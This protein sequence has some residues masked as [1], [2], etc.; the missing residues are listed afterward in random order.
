MDIEFSSKAIDLNAFE[1]P[2]FR[3][4]AKHAKLIWALDERG[5]QLFMGRKYLMELADG[6]HGNEGAPI[7]FFE[8]DHLNDI[9]DITID[10]FGDASLAFVFNVDWNTNAPE[11][12][13]AALKVLI[14]ENDLGSRRLKRLVQRCDEVA[15]TYQVTVARSMWGNLGAVNSNEGNDRLQYERN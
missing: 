4:L 15:L 13:K 5:P 8:P 9:E 11:Y 6:K 2:Q 14:G 10:D 1:I 3:E 12:L 7:V